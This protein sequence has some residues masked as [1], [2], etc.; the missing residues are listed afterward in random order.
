MPVS[1]ITALEAR[2]ATLHAKPKVP[3]GWRHD[4]GADLYIMLFPHSALSDFIGHRASKWHWG[5]LAF[6][7]KTALWAARAYIPHEVG[8]CDTLTAAVNYLNI[9]KELAQETHVWRL[10]RVGEQVVGD[11]LHY[12]DQLQ[13]V[14]TRLQLSEAT[15]RCVR[16]HANNIE[17][18]GMTREQV[19][20]WLRKK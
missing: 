17:D 20:R 3:A 9:S 11:G 15:K 6:R 18:L 4:S 14:C 10:T 19:A 1:N 12:A 16:A 8:V 13:T 7:I 5:T 2:R